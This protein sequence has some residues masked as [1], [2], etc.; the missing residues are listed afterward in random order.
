MGLDERVPRDKLS[1]DAVI[2]RVQRS[3]LK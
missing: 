1:S 2:A 3:R